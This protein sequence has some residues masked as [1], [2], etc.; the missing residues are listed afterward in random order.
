MEKEL[1]V[2]LNNVSKIQK[3]AW[4]V[5]R[6]DM[7]IYRGEGVALIGKR[8]SGKDELA[9]LI[10][11][12]SKATGGSVE[13]FFNRPKVLS[14]IGIQMPNKS[15][16]MGFKTKDV[17]ELYKN[18][19]SIKDEIWVNLLIEVFE[20]RQIW[21]AELINVE[22]S[23]SQLISLFVAIIHKPELLI[24]EDI[25]SHISLDLR[26]NLIHFL[27]NYRSENNATFIMISPDE[28]VFNELCDRVAIMEK[29]KLIYDK[30]K[31][32]WGKDETYETVITDVIEKIKS[33]QI[34]ISEDSAISSATERYIDESNIVQIALDEYIKPYKEKHKADM[35]KWNYELVVELYNLKLFVDFVKRELVRLVSCEL[36]KEDI[37]MAK[38]SITKLKKVAVEITDALK[39]H[40][41]SFKNNKAYLNLTNSLIS[42]SK[43]ILNELLPFLKNNNALAAVDCSAAKLDRVERK[44]LRMMKR[45]YIAEE[46][47]L[48]KQE[49]K[50]L[51]RQQLNVESAKD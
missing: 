37:H 11:N 47:K 7:E 16:P 9:A 13:Y 35:E 15:W 27:K 21:N 28:F 14:A 33:A 45:K 36:T 2:E 3:N 19:Y 44:K 51:R 5:R 32:E 29:G 46:M 8:N 48:Q 22:A 39:H 17:V 6:V 12:T 25:S 23:W 31:S 18:I 49:A 40:K 30:R 20:L 42:F 26:F 4:K 43:Y 10:D 1:L 24:L 34:S 50:I 38:D 41:E